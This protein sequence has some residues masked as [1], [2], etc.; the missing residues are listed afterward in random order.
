MACVFVELLS[1]VE[2]NKKFPYLFRGEPCGHLSG[3]R[4]AGYAP[5]MLI[6]FR[7]RLCRVDVDILNITGVFLHDV[8]I[9]VALIEWIWLLAADFK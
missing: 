7:M 4:W 9:N 8:S 6:M 2:G 1:S 5:H 3:D